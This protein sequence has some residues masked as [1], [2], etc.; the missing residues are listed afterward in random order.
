MAHMRFAHDATTP[1]P[2][3]RNRAMSS[4]VSAK[5]NSAHLMLCPPLSKFRHRCGMHELDAGGALEDTEPLVFFCTLPRIAG[6]RI[7]NFSSTRMD[8]LTVE[9]HSIRSL[10][11]STF[12]FQLSSF[13]VPV[14]SPYSVSDTE[15]RPDTGAAT[16]PFL[17]EN[18]SPHIF[19]ICRWSRPIS[20]GDVRYFTLAPSPRAG[21]GGCPG[22]GL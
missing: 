1:P 21:S 2:P 6:S 14:I 4:V 7:T 20:K 16:F 18:F 15:D 19:E 5:G 22:G 9:R 12:A 3:Q 10:A 17:E 11:S 8:V 13:I